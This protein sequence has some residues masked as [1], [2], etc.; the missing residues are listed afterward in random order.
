MD[1]KRLLLALVLSLMFIMTWNMFFPPDNGIKHDTPSIAPNKME[2]EQNQEK[3]ITK[4]KKEYTSF[5]MMPLDNGEYA[6][7]IKSIN[8]DLIE[9]KFINGGTSIK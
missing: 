3:L 2:T 4:N 9:I 8:T 5:G 7:I 6:E 1:L